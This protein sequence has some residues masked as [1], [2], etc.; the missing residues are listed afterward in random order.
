M[1]RPGLKKQ[2]YLGA[3]VESEVSFR[4][5]VVAEMS[6]VRILP[7]AGLFSLLIFSLSLS[8]VCPEI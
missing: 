7:G 5:K 4:V 3:M 2:A 1:D 8:C 6:W